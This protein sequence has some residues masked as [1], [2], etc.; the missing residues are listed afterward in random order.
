M[1]TPT[2]GR[3]DFSAGCCRCVADGID[4]GAFRLLQLFT[5]PL[6]ADP[7][8]FVGE[9]LPT[10]RLAVCEVSDGVDDVPQRPPAELVLRPP[11]D[12]GFANLRRH[13]SEESATI[14]HQ[15]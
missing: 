9:V 10:P 12:D 11:L 1:G 14:R 15:L 2:L 7:A 5:C 4:D 13:E 8:L 3:N 6:Q